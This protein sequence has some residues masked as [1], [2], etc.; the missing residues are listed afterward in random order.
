M[1]RR[2]QLVLDCMDHAR[3]PFSKG[4]LV[5]FRARLVAGDLDRRLVERTVAL[6]GQVTGR[7]AARETARG[8]G[9]QP[10]VGGRPGGGHDQ[11][12]GPRAAQGRG[13]AGAPAGVGA[14]GGGRGA[15]R[16]G[17]H[18]ELAA[19]SLK[20]AL[21]LD[22][23]DPAALEHA[24][25]VLLGALERV[26]RLAAE[27]DGGSDGRVAAALQGARQVRD[28]NTVVGEDSVARIRRGVA[29]DRRVSVA[30][31]EMRHGRK[32]KSRRVDGY[33][34]HVLTDLDTD[35]VRAVGSRRRTSPRPRWPT[36]SAPTSTPTACG[37]ASST[38]TAPT[39]PAA[40]SATATRTSRSSARRSRYAAP[41]AGSPSPRSTSTST[42]AC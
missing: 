23:D 32:T 26:E 8:V 11:S 36:R 3:A 22:W 31:P 38:S 19:S 9:S 41:V 13:R 6:Y 40:W 14:G 7:V 18:P 34:R 10:L 4:T 29:R 1:D 33:K 28:Q 39:C 17:R 27:L 15:G 21:D 35:L 25:G 42:A 2:W 16:A 30:D 24:L 37:S 5:A 12:V 20:A